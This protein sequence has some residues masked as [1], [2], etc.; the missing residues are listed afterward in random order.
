MDSFT[1]QTGRGSA[2]GFNYTSAFHNNIHNMAVFVQPLTRSW[3]TR[4]CWWIISFRCRRN[5]TNIS[6]PSM[7]SYKW[8]PMTAHNCQKTHIQLLGTS[9][10]SACVR[11][12][13]STC[14]AWMVWGANRRTCALI[15]VF[16]T[17]G[18]GSK[19]WPIVWQWLIWSLTCS[20]MP[21]SRMWF[22]LQVSHLSLCV[23]E[24]VFM[25]LSVRQS[26]DDTG[27]AISCRQKPIISCK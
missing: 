25:Q 14:R 24:E 10:S 19:C 1:A 21:F 13:K 23:V 18:T 3:A 17:S 15:P 27:S 22:A 20:F 2:P 11:G 5:V 9:L 4:C 12:K 8:R 26:Y 16:Q 6:L 7:S